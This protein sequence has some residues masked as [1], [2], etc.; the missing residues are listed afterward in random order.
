MTQ[1]VAHTSW[2]FPKTG[3]NDHTHLELRKIN[4]RLSPKADY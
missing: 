2:V 3:Q 4:R 1:G